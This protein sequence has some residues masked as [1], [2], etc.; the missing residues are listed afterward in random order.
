MS[1]KKNKTAVVRAVCRNCDTPLVGRYC[2]V[3]GQDVFAG[4]NHR[5][6]EFFSNSLNVLFAWDSKIFRTLW[7]L[8]AFPGRLTKEYLDGRITRYV[9]PSKLFWFITIVFFALLLSQIKVGDAEKER[10]NE[11]TAL[12]ADEQNNPV[13]EVNVEKSETDTVVTNA[14]SKAPSVGVNIGNYFID[15]IEAFNKKATW[16]GF[17]SYLSSYAPYAVMLL[18]PLFA[19]LVYGFFRRKHLYYTDYM[20][21]AMHF[22][23][24]IFLWFSL[25]MVVGKIFPRLEAGG[26]VLFWIP[27]TYLCIALWRV[28]RPRVVPMIFKVLLLML[29]C[30]IAMAVMI[31]LFLLVYFLINAY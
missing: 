24:F 1:R 5:L 9:H 3:C 6:R 27:V 25:A 18:I 26:I 17:R 8:I 15:N 11:A 12:I 16:E 28:Y 23:S 14:E 21:F 2:H 31:L 13:D 22:H 10:F 20:V 19:A 7:A 30:A 4:T 29:I